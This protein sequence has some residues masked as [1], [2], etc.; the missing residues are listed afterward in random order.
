MPRLPS[1]A[2]LLRM[3]APS[4]DKWG[5]PPPPGVTPEPV[6]PGQESVWDYPRPPKL[7]PL[8][9]RALVR[10]GDRVVADSRRCYEI[11][12]T[13]GA[14]VPYFPPE[15]VATDLLE[16]QDV[17]TLC[18]WKGAGLQYDLVDGNRRLDAAA[19]SYPDPLTDLGGG[20]EKAAGWYGFYPAK[21]SCFLDGE[22]VR[23]QAG[24]YAGWITDRIAGPVKGAPGT[25]H[26]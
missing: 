15:D 8:E 19:F 10:W 20:Y 26:W 21:L 17:V 25:G 3:L 9:A 12:E 23:P 5:P 13:A 4:R 22:A 7:R 1:H 18:E 14:P 11:V 2:D 24:I 6:G 16:V